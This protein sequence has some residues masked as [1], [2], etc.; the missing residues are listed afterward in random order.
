MIDIDHLRPGMRIDGV[1]PSGRVE[2]VDVRRLGP[3]AVLRLRDQYGVVHSQ[4]LRVDQLDD[5]VEVAERD[6]SLDGDGDR[7]R[8]AI[9]AQRILDAHLLN[10]LLALTTANVE[11]LPHQTQ[12]V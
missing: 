3:T 9:D 4:V 6:G 5:A 10:P 2:I 8:L 7:F 12:A 11:P 1:H